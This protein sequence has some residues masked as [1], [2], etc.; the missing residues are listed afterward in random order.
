MGNYTKNLRKRLGKKS[1]PTT[2]CT[3][4]GKGEKG[5]T[6]NVSACSNTNALY[7]NKSRE[8]YYCK[9]CADEINWIGGRADCLMLYG[10]ELLCELD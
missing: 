9:A 10:T 2:K 3:K 4:T 6:C 7:F 8:K 1:P 5:G